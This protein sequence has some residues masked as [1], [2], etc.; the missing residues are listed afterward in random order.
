MAR[1]GEGGGRAPGPRR[2]RPGVWA[3]EGRPGAWPGT[4]QT[5]PAAMPGTAG[6]IRG[7]RL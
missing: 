5:P 2:G 6:G 1:A 3:A 4:W 7:R